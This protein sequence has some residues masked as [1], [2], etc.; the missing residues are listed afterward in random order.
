M[1]TLSENKIAFFA[2]DSKAESVTVL[3]SETFKIA[4]EKAATHIRQQIE[5]NTAKIKAIDEE[6]P[7]LKLKKDQLDKE[8]EKCQEF[9]SDSLLRKLVLDPAARSL[10]LTLKEFPKKAMPTLSVKEC[11]QSLTQCEQEIKNKSAEKAKL[12]HQL[13]SDQQ[14]LDDII[15]TTAS[16]MA[17][18]LAL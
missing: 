5:K 17:R 12:T 7:R 3:T 1:T 8:L 6:L 11:T 16:D 15:N 14:L 13:K 2:R 4:Q 18:H 9:I 10:D